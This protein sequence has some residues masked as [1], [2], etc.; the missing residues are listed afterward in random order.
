M[1]TVYEIIRECCEELDVDRI[2]DES[3]F[4]DDLNL[5]SLDFFSLITEIEMELD[6]HI[7]EYEIQ[8]LVTVGDLV[9]I[10]QE[11]V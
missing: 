6:I 9:R 5:S 8:H 1:D 2:T 7:T 11:K 4:M 10:V 3:R